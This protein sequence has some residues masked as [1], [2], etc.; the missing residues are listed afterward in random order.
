MAP[1][2]NKKAAPVQNRRSARTGERASTSGH[3][4]HFISPKKSRDRAKR[5]VVV[6]TSAAARSNT[7]RSRITSLLNKDP[8]SAPPAAGPIPDQPQDPQISGDTE[9][10]DWEDVVMEPPPSL[11]PPVPVPILPPSPGPNPNVK[12]EQSWN[13]LLPTLE[14]PFT[15]YCQATHGQRPPAILESIHYECTAGCPCVASTTIRCLYLT[16][17]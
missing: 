15:E 4:V 16:C 2:Q 11:P 14:A 9:M 8:R 1:V 12:L 3:G 5:A 13:A 10:E 7:L 17:T 6:N